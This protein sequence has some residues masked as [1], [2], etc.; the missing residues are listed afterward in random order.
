[1][2]NQR[3]WKETQLVAKGCTKDTWRHSTVGRRSLRWEDVFIRVYGVD[4]IASVLDSPVEKS[5]V[6][7]HK[8]CLVK[9]VAPMKV[10][11]VDLIP[12]CVAEEIPADVGPRPQ[13]FLRWSCVDSPSVCILSVGDSSFVTNCA[14]TYDRCNPRYL[15]QELHDALC[16]SWRT[17]GVLPRPAQSDF[18][19]HVKRHFNTDASSLATVGATSY[20]LNKGGDTFDATKII[21]SGPIGAVDFVRGVWVAG[22]SL[23]GRNGRPATMEARLFCWCQVGIGWRRSCGRDGRLF[24]RCDRCA[25]VCCLS[26]SRV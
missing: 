12:E 11:L 26:Q 4:S 22:F 6:G 13:D 8:F 5:I 1:M 3:W 2:E 25:G 15:V 14:N 21:S 7:A 16:A 23:R 19:S 17:R 24:V 20:G 9:M 10:S 18:F